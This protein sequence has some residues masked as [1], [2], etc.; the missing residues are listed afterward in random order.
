M[1]NFFI[2]NNLKFDF[3]NHDNEIQLDLKN[4]VGMIAYFD[5]LN[6]GFMLHFS[7]KYQPIPL[8]YESLFRLCKPV[9]CPKCGNIH[10]HVHDEDGEDAVELSEYQPVDPN[11]L[12]LFA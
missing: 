5:C 4:V 2:M 9:T 10:Y 3:V 7:K 11:Q 1:L 6:C 8:H 12:R